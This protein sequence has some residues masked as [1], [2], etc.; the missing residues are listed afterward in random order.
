MH[1]RKFE[2]NF[3]VFRSVENMIPCRR[4]CLGRGETRALSQKVTKD[5]NN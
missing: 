3:V 1:K 2:E 5:E 4:R